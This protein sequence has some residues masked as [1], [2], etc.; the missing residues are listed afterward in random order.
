[1]V[2]VVCSALDQYWTMRLS[3]LRTRAAT[4]ELKHKT[5]AM[6]THLTISVRTHTEKHAVKPLVKRVSLTRT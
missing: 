4:F 5:V 2:L 1:M 3:D 6:M